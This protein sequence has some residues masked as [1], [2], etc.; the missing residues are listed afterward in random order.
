MQLCG[1]VPLWRLKSLWVCAIMHVVYYWSIDGV[2]C[3][4]LVLSVSGSN[5]YQA[6]SHPVQLFCSEAEA[7]LPTCWPAGCKC[8]W[9]RWSFTAHLRKVRQTVRKPGESRGGLGELHWWV[10]SVLLQDTSNSLLTA[11]E[12]LLCMNEYLW[13][14]SINHQNNM[15]VNSWLVNTTHCGEN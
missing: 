14:V 15:L 12:P 8:Q 9:K 2:L 10:S 6:C 13:K 3:N 1:C 11:T 4:L 7:G 5:A